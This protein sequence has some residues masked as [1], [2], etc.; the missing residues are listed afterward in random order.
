VIEIP[1]IPLNKIADVLKFSKSQPKVESATPLTFE[2]L[3]Q[4]FG[5]LLYERHFNQPISGT[6]EIKGLRDYALVYVNGKQVGELNRYFKNYSMEINIPFNATLSI[7]VENMGR[8][9]FGANIIH[10]A[11]GIIS[12]VLINGIEITDNWEMTPLPMNE[13]PK[14]NFLQNTPQHVQALSKKPIV[15]EGTFNLNEIG[16]TFL[17]IADWGKGIVF[18]NGINIGRYWH[19]GPQQTLYIPGVWLKQGKNTITIFEQL[20]KTPKTA[21]R[22]VKTPVL[23]DL[24]LPKE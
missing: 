7:L 23:T 16:D 11:K 17:D 12:P 3:K 14:M 2:Q 10:N 6:L 4:P 21:I 18:I 24:R 9:N 1:N 15:Y 13:P 22:T 19:Y 8:I 5:Y 20:N